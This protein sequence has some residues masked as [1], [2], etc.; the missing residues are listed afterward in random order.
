MRELGETKNC[1]GMSAAGNN[2]G[3]V[4]DRAL[5]L[6]AFLAAV[7]IP[8]FNHGRTVIS[9]LDAVAASGKLII[10]VDDGS[11]DGT[12]GL[13]KEWK[14]SRPQSV[15]EVRTHA[16]NLGKAAAL[17]TGFAAAAERG[18]T[19]AA[20]IDADGQ[21]DARDIPGLL[22]VAERNKGALIL[23]TRPAQMAECPGRCS[24]GRRLAGMAVRLECGLRL[25]DTQ[26]GLRVYPL[27]MIG[28]A[29][30]T[31]GRFSFETEIIVRAAWAGFQVVEVPVRCIY[32]SA[33]ERVSHFRPWRDTVHHI[34]V[35]TRLFC[36]GLFKRRPSV[37]ASGS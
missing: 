18:C 27:E 26:C 30:C 15:C 29:P 33:Q 14:L 6:Q 32:F 36:T 1:S 11:T 28:Q 24:R 25:S 21:L 13:L 19:H 17:A 3:S 10:V 12:G 22:E 8:T 34:L 37:P 7:V 31:A 23:G 9:V 16:R 5:L 35:H 20:T 2:T 4:V